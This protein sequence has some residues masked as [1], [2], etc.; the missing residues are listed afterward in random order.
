M[1]LT[2]IAG[3]RSPLFFSE[4]D[5][6]RAIIDEL[7]EAA[8][9]APSGFNNQPWHYIFVHKDAKTRRAL[10]RAL[11]PG[12]G[13]ASAAPWL[14]VVAASRQDQKGANGVPYHV[15]DSALSVMN[16]VIEAEHHRLRTHQMGGFFGG[17]VRKALGIPS[18][19][20]VLVVIALGKEGKPASL[21]ARFTNALYEK[22]RERLAKPRTRK[23]P[24]E[25]FFFGKWQD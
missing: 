19:H 7:I 14:I 9:W 10:E 11:A 23:E 8:R 20:D 1:P 4:E 12:N 25:N 24:N 3:R 13:W 6:P 18:T 17:R 15:Y 5:V 22:L 21:K 2:E 16:L